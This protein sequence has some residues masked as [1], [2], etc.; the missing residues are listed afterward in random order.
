[1]CKAAGSAAFLVFLLAGAPAAA[2]DLWLE[3]STFRPAPHGLVSVSVLVGQGFLGDTVPRDPEH[4]ERFVLG[5]APVVGLPGADPAGTVRVGD[6]GAATLLYRGT[7]QPITLEAAKFE[8][9][10][11]EE[12]LEHVIAARAKAGKSNAPGRE[13][14]G[15]CAKALLAVGGISSSA[16]E[17]LGCPF[18]IVPLADPHP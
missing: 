16:P 9:Y 17:A 4:L 7:P 18:E 10:L 6:A 2:H 11:R 15:R 13:R 5:T 12:G 1:M 3:P 8:S 14:Y